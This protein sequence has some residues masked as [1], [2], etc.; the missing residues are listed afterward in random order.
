MVRKYIFN[1]VLIASLSLPMFAMSVPPTSVA[2]S[3]PGTSSV[4]LPPTTSNQKQAQKPQVLPPTM[5]VYA[6]MP[7]LINP[8]IIL[9]N[10]NRFNG[11]VANDVYSQASRGGL[12]HFFAFNPDTGYI[13]DEYNRT[14]GLF[15]VNYSRAYT[16][17]EFLLNPTNTDICN[18]LADRQLFPSEVEPLYTDCPGNPPYSTNQIHLS[19]LDPGSGRGTNS[20]IGELVQV[21]LAID[22]GIGAPDYIPLG[23]PGG[24]LSLLLA[25]NE[26]V[27]SLDNSLPGLQAIASPW[28]GRMRAMDPIG[29]YPVVPMQA[30]IEQFTSGFP[31]GAIID[32]G[33]PVMVY[34]VGFPD[35]PQD[36]VMPMWTFPDATAII[37]GTEV[38]LKDSALPGVV[39][40]APAVNIESPA[41]GT[42]FLRNQPVSITFSITGDQGPFTY[43]VSSDESVVATGVTISGTLTLNL[44]V[45][46]NS[47]GRPDGHDL[48]VHA[49]NQYNIPGDDTVFLGAASSIYVPLVGRDSSGL[50]NVYSPG[51]QSTLPAPVSPDTTLRIGV[52]WVMNYHNPDLNLGQ[53]QPDA[54]GLYTWLGINGWVKTF[55]YG[56]DAAWERDWRDCTL[57]GKDCTYGVDRAQ[58][59]Y[60][61]GHGSPSSWYFG[62]TKDYGG[63][64]GGN[65]RFQTVRW[66]AFSSCQ[67]VRA[68]PYVGPGDPPLTDWFNSFQGS[69]MILGFHS[70]MGDVPFGFS[71]GFNMY[72]FM[73]SIFPW[74]QP[75]IS[76]AWVNTAF[77]MNAG[78]PSYL[79][80]VGNFNPVNFKL[81]PAGAGPLP[82]LTGIYQFRW[83]WWDE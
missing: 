53:T 5:P 67:T 24:H 42:V 79:Y 30:A 9:G 28:F 70:V 56:N 29:F 74:M 63:A 50:K 23:G 16:E 51:L 21:P 52:E 75:S 69:Y 77:Q 1:I 71:F 83:V 54:E 82:P 20:T 14:G 81:P 6:I 60:F 37:S 58:F 32:A 11:A 46:P 18:F 35:V 39:G 78:K 25:G 72:N 43:T 68:G 27:P 59:V 22:I 38:S 49:V 40:F 45:L 3:D 65:S 19:T 31:A 7:T 33:T 47:G 66:A 55:D 13:I 17:T 12:D 57:G 73:Y 61:S 76:Q 80:T 64:W 36:A 2:Q 41:D 48:S 62:V 44:G 4:T 26:N 8:D 34:Y 15:A 10:A